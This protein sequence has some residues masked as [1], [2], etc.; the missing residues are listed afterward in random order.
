MVHRVL[1]LLAVFCGTTFTI[2]SQVNC[3]SVKSLGRKYS[4]SQILEAI[5]K[6]DWCGYF[7]ESEHYQLNFDDGAKVELFSML[8]L[9]NK[10]DLDET[11]FQNKSTTDQGVY[12]I[13]ESG[14]LIRMLSARNTSKN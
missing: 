11:C 12:K 3:A 10:N 9:E 2:Q 14:I 7:H 13:H 1:L 5:N 4:T 8:E 6:A